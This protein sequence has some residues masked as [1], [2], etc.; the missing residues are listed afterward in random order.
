MIFVEE[1]E[2]KL[3]VLPG[4][5]TVTVEDGKAS[6]ALHVIGPRTTQSHPNVANLLATCFRIKFD[7]QTLIV[8]CT[9]LACHFC[10]G[11]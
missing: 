2:G 4:L 5:K 9:V 8:C 1:E 10:Q 11:S 6:M 7:K 3:S